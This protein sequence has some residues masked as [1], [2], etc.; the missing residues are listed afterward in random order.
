MEERQVGHSEGGE[1]IWAVAAEASRGRAARRGARTSAA[2]IFQV[3]SK[4][5]SRS[6]RSL[7]QQ[8]KRK[9]SI[10]ISERMFV[11]PGSGKFVFR[12]ACK[13]GFQRRVLMVL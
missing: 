4:K 10:Y 1:K 5:C 2:T 3:S 9:I 6:R 13:G 8:S 12:E 11:K 7:G